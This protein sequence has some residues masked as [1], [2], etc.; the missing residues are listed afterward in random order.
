MVTALG[1]D[2]GQGYLLGRP[3][4][5]PAAPR[6]IETLRLDATRMTVRR[7]VHGRIA[8]ARAGGP[9]RAAVHAPLRATD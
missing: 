8:R 9:R 6:P 3:A 4:A 5:E 7:A 2:L 1:V